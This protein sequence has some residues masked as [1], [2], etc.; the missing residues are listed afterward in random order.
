MRN[1]LIILAIIVL[2]FIYWRGVK[3]V[4]TQKGM[5]CEYHIVYALCTAKNNKATMPGIWDILKAGVKF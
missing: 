1:R 2:A 3:S 5:S 4:T